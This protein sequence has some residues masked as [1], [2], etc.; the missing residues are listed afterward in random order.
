MAGKLSQRN[1]GASAS[2]ARLKLWKDGKSCAKMKDKYIICFLV[3]LIGSL[4]S[5]IGIDAY[6]GSNT[7]EA[8]SDMPGYYAKSFCDCMTFLIMGSILA[9]KDV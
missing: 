4:I 6:Y 3:M 9:G 2:A 5:V 1:I 8:L 7:Y